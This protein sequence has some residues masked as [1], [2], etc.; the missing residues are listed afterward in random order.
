M[1]IL[2]STFTALNFTLLKVHLPNL[3]TRL[4]LQ[5]RNILTYRRNER[6]GVDLKLLIARQNMDGSEIEFS[7][8]LIE[9]QNCGAMSYI[10]CTS[11]VY[12]TD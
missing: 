12:T 8:M 9:D 1:G 6:K 4:S 2:F 10:D 5:V 7:D 3:N 11:S